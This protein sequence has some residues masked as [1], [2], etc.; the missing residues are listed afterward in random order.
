MTDD[1]LQQLRQ[2]FEVM[3]QL[4]APGG[5][6][7]DRAQS[8]QTLVPFLL[9]ETYEAIQAVEEG[10]PEELAE[11]LGD[12]LVEVAM[13]SAIAAEQ[14]SFDIG[15]VA[16]AATEKMIG[17]H[18]HVFG[19]LEVAGVAQVLSNWEELKRQ[20]KPERESALDGIPRSLPALA[21]AAAIQRRQDRGSEPGVPTGAGPNPALAAATALGQLA[22]GSQ[23]GGSAEELVGE[24]LFWVVALAGQ[25]QV[26]AEGAL[27]RVAAQRRAAW[28]QTEVQER[29]QAAA[30]PANPPADASK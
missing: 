20:E 19:E 29:R 2:L 23:A 26:D 15:D 18:P 1:D 14:G 11:E 27:R 17:R 4:R 6:P 5:C 10:S 16:R 25:H 21:L 13:H 28:R 3:E 24:L 8:H 9:E 7:W 12:L 22:A 30:G